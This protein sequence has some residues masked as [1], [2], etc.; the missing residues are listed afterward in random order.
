MIDYQGEKQEAWRIFHEKFQCDHEQSAVRKQTVRGG[1]IHYVRQCLRC[2]QRVSNAMSREVAIELAGGNEPPPFDSV[3]FEAW[4]KAK[5]DHAAEISRRFDRSAFFEEYS[6]YLAGPVWAEKRRL[7]LARAN[8]ICEGC[9]KA[10]ANEVHHLSY[11]HVGSEFLFELVAVCQQ[12]H[13]RLHDSG[14]DLS[15]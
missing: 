9:G 7:V 15:E 3:L 12:C 14:V 4:E 5:A 10:P 13:N 1:G 11:K 8:S 6:R 2:G